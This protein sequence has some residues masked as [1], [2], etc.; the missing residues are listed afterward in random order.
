LSAGGDHDESKN[1][2]NKT[3]EK[4]MNQAAVFFTES[5]LHAFQFSEFVIQ[6]DAQVERVDTENESNNADT[7]SYFV[8]VK[9]LYLKG[10]P[11]TPSPY[12]RHNRLCKHS[13]TGFNQILQAP[14]SAVLQDC[15]ILQ[16]F[17]Q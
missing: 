4:Q 8:H 5:F 14:P 16:R 2:G 11:G 1:G 6:A 13:L 17:G 3:V 7:D 9:P 10:Q 12:R 15:W